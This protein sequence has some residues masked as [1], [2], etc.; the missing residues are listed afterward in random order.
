M[1]NI[2]NESPNTGRLT[3]GNFNEYGQ[4][5]A[6]IH[7]CVSRFTTGNFH[8][9]R[10]FEKHTHTHTHIHTGN[11]T[12]S[13]EYTRHTRTCAHTHDT[14]RQTDTHTHTLLATRLRNVL[15]RSG[16][17]L[18]RCNAIPSWYRQA[19]VCQYVPSVNMYPLGDVGVGSEI[20][21][22]KLF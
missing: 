22:I 6:C 21:K 19:V 13:T 11:C 16:C 12:S 9:L 2:L 8:D 4:H 18:S 1:T 14:N 15:R 3:T 20:K 7:D 10:R 17:S 5:S